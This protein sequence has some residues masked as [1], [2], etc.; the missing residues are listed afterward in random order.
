MD[1]PKHISE[2]AI[3]GVKGI[4]D[5]EGTTAKPKSN[6]SDVKINDKLIFKNS[7][8]DKTIEVQAAGNGAVGKSIRILGGNASVGAVSGLNAGSVVL[9]SGQGANAP[10]DAG[11]DGGNGGDIINTLGIGGAGDGFGE[12]GS[13]GEYVIEGPSSTIHAYYDNTAS[14]AGG[15]LTNIHFYGMNDTPLE[16]EYA[17]IIAEATS[18]SPLLEDGKIKIQTMCS[19]TLTDALTMQG[20]A[21]CN[22][23]LV[24][25]G[26]PDKAAI[27]TKGEGD[28]SA[29]TDFIIEGQ[30]AGTGLVT[31]SGLPGGDLFITGGEGGE[32]DG[33]NNDGGDGGDLY[34]TGGLGGVNT[35]SGIEGETGIVIIGENADSDLSE[36]EIRN[37][38]TVTGS[39]G[40]N[41]TPNYILDVGSDTAM[42][43]KIRVKGEPTDN[44]L[45]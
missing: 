35:G 14:P 1:I 13:Q 42:F 43:D 6:I 29:G 5:K 8:S 39:L 7:G 9:E 15:E 22:E 23:I 34:L 33:S 38:L 2:H 11:G 44:A 45:S 20:E 40:I 19:G 12:P 30:F 10:V 37:N 25:V 21:D 18:S 27:L 17:K 3:L 26:D 36:T 41:K 24:L 4:W 32:A 16:V 28:N 31:A